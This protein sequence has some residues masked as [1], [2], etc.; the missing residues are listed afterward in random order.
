MQSQGKVLV[1]LVAPEGKITGVHTQIKEPEVGPMPRIIDDGTT[2]Q[3]PVLG[4][5]RT[6][7]PALLSSPAFGISLV[8]LKFDENTPDQGP[9]PIE[10]ARRWIQQV[11]DVDILRE[12][13]RVV[14]PFVRRDPF[15]LPPFNEFIPQ[16]L[17]ESGIQLAILNPDADDVDDRSPQL[18]NGTSNFQEVRQQFWFRIERRRSQLQA[19]KRIQKAAN[20]FNLVTF[21]RTALTVLADRDWKPSTA[22]TESCRFQELPGDPMWFWGSFPSPGPVLSF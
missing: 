8:E 13:E 5:L 7:V 16:A 14:P 21:G 4:V 17:V 11:T 10:I 1:D 19:R 12:P 15:K 9:N 3:S 22:T 18:I 6:V 2:I 20:T